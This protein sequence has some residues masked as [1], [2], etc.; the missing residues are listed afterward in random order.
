MKLY[1]FRQFLPGF[2]LLLSL[3]QSVR[4]ESNSISVLKHFF[5]TDTP[6]D[7]LSLCGTG[8]NSYQRESDI[9]TNVAKTILLTVSKDPKDFEQVKAG[10]KFLPGET[11]CLH[12]RDNP[13]TITP[14]SHYFKPTMRVINM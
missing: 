7:V 9:Q 11:L 8:I 14:K 5:Q 4:S 13:S 1:P 6:S 2:V 10:T 3:E 12:I